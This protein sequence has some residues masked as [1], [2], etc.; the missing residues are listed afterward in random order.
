MKQG[1]FFVFSLYGSTEHTEYMER[2][3]L[4]IFLKIF[5]KISSRK[6]IHNKALPKS[7]V[8]ERLL[9]KDFY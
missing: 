9:V 6:A 8:F 4:K 3:W 7:E 2:F 1:A 5:V